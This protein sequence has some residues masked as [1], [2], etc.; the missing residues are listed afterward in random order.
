MVFCSH[1]YWE[2]KI[3]FVSKCLFLFLDLGDFLL[4]FFFNI[5]S[6]LSVSLGFL[7]CTVGF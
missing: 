6:L 3:L 2:L 1:D 4:S 5:L 7:F